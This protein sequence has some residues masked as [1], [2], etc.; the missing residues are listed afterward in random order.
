MKKHEIDDICNRL[1]Q[2]KDF[3]KLYYSIDEDNEFKIWI[4]HSEDKI[5]LDRFF[6]KFHEIMPDNLSKALLELFDHNNQQELQKTLKQNK[7]LLTLFT[8]QLSILEMINEKWNLYID[9]SSDEY[10]RIILTP[11]NDI[12]DFLND[13]SVER[14]VTFVQPRN[15][16]EK[17]E[18]E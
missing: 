12:G 9:G 18:D 1:L 8:H 17:G 2:L 6:D 11:D 15:I 13:N 4:E 5:A 10:I 16:Q 14:T 3:F 7:A